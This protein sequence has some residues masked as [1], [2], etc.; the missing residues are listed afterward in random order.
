MILVA[1]DPASAGEV[2]EVSWVEEGVEDDPPM[3]QPCDD[4]QIPTVKNI[5]II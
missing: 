3:E 1:G 5:L 2:R 4:T